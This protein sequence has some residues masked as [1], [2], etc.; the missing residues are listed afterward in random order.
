MKLIWKRAAFHLALLVSGPCRCVCSLTD[1]VYWL[2][3]LKGEFPLVQQ[4][5]L[6]SIT[7][8]PH[9]PELSTSCMISWFYM[10]LTA[11][12]SPNSISYWQSECFCCS[13]WVSIQK[14][15]RW[16]PYTETP[17]QNVSFPFLYSIQ[18]KSNL[19]YTLPTPYVFLY[20]IFLYVV[21]Q[22]KHNQILHMCK[23]GW[24][25]RQNQPFPAL[26][27]QFAICF[28]LVL[29]TWWEPYRR[30][31]CD[32]VIIRDKMCSRGDR[33]PWDSPSVQ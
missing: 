2:I 3:K 30:P 14:C 22:Q 20:T 28:Q 19:L 26:C 31:P 25:S 6:F 29:L 1:I 15:L 33:S 5:P 16:K 11:R 32:D 27:L 24:I 18:I 9:T 4:F 21:W 13:S 7:W 8:L 12:L 23:N 10:L 17:M